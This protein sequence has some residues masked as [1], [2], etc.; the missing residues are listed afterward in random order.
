V[1]LSQ[2]FGRLGLA[3]VFFASLLLLV[4]GARG[5][6]ETNASL[7]A[8]SASGSLIATNTLSTALPV[9]NTGETNAQ[10]VLV[11]SI[12]I[13]GG[14][15]TEP[16]TLPES[17]GTIEAGRLGFLS[18]TFT[19][20]PGT[21]FLPG[22]I[23]TI[24]IAGSFR[25]KTTTFQFASTQSLQIPPAGHGT[26]PALSSSSPV[27]TGGTFAHQ[28]PD[29]NE[30]ANPGG[31]GWTVPEGPTRPAAKASTP[32]TVQPVVLNDPPV[33]F[34][35]NTSLGFP[36]PKGPN[37]PSGAVSSGGIV[38]ETWNWMAA[39][40]A[41][42]VNFTEIDPTMLFPNDLDGGFCCDQQVQYVPKI[43]RFIWVMQFG[44][45]ANDSNRY[46]IAAANPNSNL[47][48]GKSWKYWD[49]TST[50]VGGGPGGWD[51]PDTSFGNK[52]FY[53]SGDLTVTGPPNSSGGRVVI[54][55]PL[56]EIESGS[57]INFLYTNWSDGQVAWGDRMTQ[58]AQ[59]E[60]FWPGQ[61]DNTDLRIFSWPES[62][63]DYGWSANV[64]IDKWPSLP[65]AYPKNY[66]GTGIPGMVSMT[67]APNPMNWLQ[68]LPDMPGNSIQGATRLISTGSNAQNE[69]LFAWSAS[70]GMG[71]PQPHVQW[72]ALDVNDNFNLISQQQVWNSKYAF[73]F[74]TF[75]VNSN[76]DI[77]MSLQFGGGGNYE[78]HVVGFWGDFVAYITTSSNVGE[79]Y[80]M[81]TGPQF[82][83]H[84]GDFVTIR[85][86]T[87]DLK[88][89]AAFGYGMQTTGTDTHY[90]LFSRPGD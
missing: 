6:N 43:N 85:P 75:A 74:P 12:S 2:R 51:Y 19:A 1:K 84:F 17:L 89:F 61:I 34:E 46:R 10:E 79:G 14:T 53:L 69:L 7:I 41:D 25:E 83:D 15:L 50:Q 27:Q 73:A 58:N 86:Y 33:D 4:V 59:D 5:V 29:F 72:V 8:G 11:S 71:F 32:T 80:N 81:T 76:N 82:G 13:T 70:S 18:A 42:G 62:G 65:A 24:S 22:G 28:P 16:T 87:P 23:Y 26:A 63:T 45:G 68:Y 35:T 54:R 90:V 3:C 64:P 30:E 49:I 55:I 78:N 40:S 20:V 21:A 56:A 60:L 44:T 38:F 9:I 39:F 52:Y 66:L 37:E 77:G 67:P 88:R 48:S 36:H 57:N 47:A 31:N